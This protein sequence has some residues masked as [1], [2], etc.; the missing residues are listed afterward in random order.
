MFVWLVRLVLLGEV[1]EFGKFY[2]VVNVVEV[3]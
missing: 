2:E 3:G 1:D